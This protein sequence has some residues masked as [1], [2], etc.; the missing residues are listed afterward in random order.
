[1]SVDTPVIPAEAAPVDPRNPKVRMAALFDPGS[2]TIITA[3][4]DSGMLAGAGRVEGTLAVAFASDPS[5][6]GGAMGSA[7]CKVILAA[8]ARALAD[9]CPVIGLWHSGGARLREGVLSLHAVGEVFAIMTRA[10]GRMR[11]FAVT[12][13][14]TVLASYRNT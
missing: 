11:H 3:E 5:I 4:D 1:M 12:A 13:S 14:R 8:Y 9:N 6:Q 7:G 10:S 2:F